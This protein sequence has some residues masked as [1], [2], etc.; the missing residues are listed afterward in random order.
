MPVHVRSTL[1]CLLLLGA[2]AAPV[3]AH[4]ASPSARAYRAGLAAYVEDYPPLV[5]SL[6]QTTFPINRLVGIDA[7]A[8]PAE[9]LI[10]L[11]NVDTAYTVG[12]LDLRAQPLV[13]HVPAIAGRY[14]SFELVDAYTNVFAYIGSRVTGT[15]AGDYAIVAPGYTG[16]L[17]AGVTVIRSPTP[18]V[19]MLGR[20]LIDGP[21]DLPAVG[22]ILGQYSLTPLSTFVAGGAP[23]ASLVLNAFPARAPAVLPTGLAFFDAA[24]QVEAQDPPP[25]AEQRSLAALRGYG[26]GPGITTSAATLSAPVRAALVRAV[27][28][29]PARVQA[30][31][32]ALSAH[33]ERVNAGWSLPNPKTGDA[34]ADYALRAVIARIGLWANTPAEAA[35]EMADEDSAGRR[36]S[37][38]HRYAL[39]FTGPPPAKA[40]WSLTMYNARLALYANPLGRSALGDRSPGLQRAGDGAFTL[41]LQHAAPAGHVANWLPAPSG[42]FNVTLRLYVPER[43]VLDGRWTPPGIVCIDCRHP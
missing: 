39:H 42:R 26:I 4:A 28:D 37:G 17:P 18:D 22:A 27:H 43:S 33:S 19:L 6:S 38:A 1:A 23:G 9:Q 40:F 3:A 12:R 7:T 16:Q 31:S 5:D 32:A 24:D 20:T 41:Y 2:L 29:G 10:V 11:P 34:G 14:Y 36:L 8:T 35:Y 25:A 21:L 13:V 30:L 15:A